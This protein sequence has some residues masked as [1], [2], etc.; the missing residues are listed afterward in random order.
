VQSTSGQFHY[1]R[2][3]FSSQ[4]KSKIGNILA[5]AYVESYDVSNNPTVAE[6]ESM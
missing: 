5:K 3:A 4:L 6:G 2:A 1:R